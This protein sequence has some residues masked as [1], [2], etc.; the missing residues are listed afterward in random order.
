MSGGHFGYLQHRIHDIADDI[1]KVIDDNDSQET[2]KWGDA[3]G[4]G[5]EPETIAE[6]EKAVKLLREAFVRVQRIDWLLSCDDGE[7]TFHDRLKHELEG[8]TK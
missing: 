3:I 2:N 8:L 4:R 6:F 1:Q 7:D 5:Y